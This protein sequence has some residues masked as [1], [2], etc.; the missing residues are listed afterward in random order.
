MSSLLA[1]PQSL[2]SVVL[3]LHYSRA[4]HGRFHMSTWS[5]ICWL[6]VRQHGYRAGRMP[7][8]PGA[9]SHCMW[10]YCS[11][12][13]SLQH[14]QHWLGAHLLHRQAHILPAMPQAQHG[15]AAALLTPNCRHT[16]I[17]HTDIKMRN[18][19]C[20]F[21]HTLVTWERCLRYFRC[22]SHNKQWQRNEH[23]CQSGWML[24]SH[25]FRLPLLVTRWTW[26]CQAYSQ[27]RRRKNVFFLI[28]EAIWSSS[29][30]FPWLCHTLM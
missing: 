28:A 21:K 4:T 22:W 27:Y 13:P 6:L 7:A 18:E 2:P 26:P 24:I 8:K 9:Q 15:A 19:C 23:H 20:V 30:A 11:H 29:S 5:G 17:V 12:S 14:P 3:Q 1:L 16:S 25:L 10:P